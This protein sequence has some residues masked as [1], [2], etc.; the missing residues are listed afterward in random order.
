M[1]PPL[2]AL[3]QVGSCRRARSISGAVTSY[4]DYINALTVRTFELRAHW[5]A[6]FGNEKC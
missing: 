1:N 4:T 2:D 5:T 3:S 6:R